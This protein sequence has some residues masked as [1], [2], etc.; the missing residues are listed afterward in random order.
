MSGSTTKVAGGEP[1]FGDALIKRC[2]WAL[3]G[4]VVLAELVA[5][6]TGVWRS[7]AYRLPFLVALLVAIASLYSFERTPVE[8]RPQKLRSIAIALALAALVCL[9]YATTI[10]RLG[11]NVF[12]RP[13]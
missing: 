12:N 7:M 5:L 3:A 9:F 13:M 4:L 11:G 6:A 8:R 10:V 1:Q 2:K